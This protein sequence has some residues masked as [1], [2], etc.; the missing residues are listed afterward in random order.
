MF[1]KLVVIPI[2][3]KKRTPT[4]KRTPIKKKPKKRIPIKRKPKTKKKQYKQRIRKWI[5]I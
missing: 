4:R 2:K 5:R 3:A 1:E